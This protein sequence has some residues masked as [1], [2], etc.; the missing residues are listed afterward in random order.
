[1]LTPFLQPYEFKPYDLL[2]KYEGGIEFHQCK[3]TYWHKL[4]SEISNICGIYFR[5][6]YELI[7]SYNKEKCYY[8]TYIPINEL[9]IFCKIVEK[10][11]GNIT[12]N[13]EKK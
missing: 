7:N 1:M 9:I 5:P 13:F 11:G 3:F 6:Y 4:L 2:Y 10:E 12:Y 8:S